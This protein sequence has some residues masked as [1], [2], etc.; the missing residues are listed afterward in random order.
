MQRDN[1][2][3]NDA[4]PVNFSALAQKEMETDADPGLT[5]LRD[6]VVMQRIRL[7][8]YADANRRLRDKSSK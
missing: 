6:V 8:R 3:R 2:I 4:C 5:K 7:A 1:S